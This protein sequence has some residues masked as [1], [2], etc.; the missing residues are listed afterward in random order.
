MI[1]VH[2][3]LP[4]SRYITDNLRNFREYLEHRQA[5]VMTKLINITYF[6]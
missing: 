6:I 5:K 1:Q 3:F 4:L 2:Y